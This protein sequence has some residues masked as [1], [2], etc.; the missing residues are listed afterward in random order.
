MRGKS[1]V[2]VV[3]VTDEKHRRQRT[4]SAAYRKREH[5][6]AAFSRDVAALIGTRGNRRLREDVDATDA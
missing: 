6:V 3:V 4:G 2:T 5:G 1:Y